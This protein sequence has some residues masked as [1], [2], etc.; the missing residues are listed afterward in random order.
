[1]ISAQWLYDG[2][3]GDERTGSIE[4]LGNLSQQ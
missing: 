3:N 1:M 4:K 2:S